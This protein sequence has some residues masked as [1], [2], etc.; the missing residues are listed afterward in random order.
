MDEQIVVVE[1][2]KKKRAQAAGMSKLFGGMKRFVPVFLLFMFLPFF[3]ALVMDPPDLRFFTGAT[4]EKNDLRVWVEPSSV[5]VDS[6]SSVELSVVASFE[7][8]EKLI[9]GLNVRVAADSG[10]NLSNSSIISN[11]PFKGQMVIGTF[12]ATALKSGTY[13][14]RI[15]E[16][17]VSAP[18]FAGSLS[19]VSGSASLMAR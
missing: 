5:V 15:P 18:G 4:V 19:V 9:P 8:E 2:K 13:E 17:L 10:V 16:G 6:G 3:M 1:E 7:S 11:K 12:E 14:I